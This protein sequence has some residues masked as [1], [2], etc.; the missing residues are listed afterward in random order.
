MKPANL[1]MPSR[2]GVLRAG[3]AASLAAP[4]LFVRR[5]AA[6]QQ[7]V[8]RTPGGAYD[9]IKRATVYQPFRAETGIEIVPVAATVAKLLA[10]FKA[11]AVEIDCVDTGNDTLLQLQT[12]GALEPL[13]YKAF[14]F[15]DP[16]DIDPPVRL[17][18]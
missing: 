4:Y 17:P 16:A 15:T 2:R 13:D 18:Y 9:D 6:A 12:A 8:V 3:V 5:A 11:G 1:V 14:T 7:L 10:M